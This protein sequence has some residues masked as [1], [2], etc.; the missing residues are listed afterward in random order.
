[1]CRARFGPYGCD[2]LTLPPEESA[3]G[4]VRYVTQ[5]HALCRIPCSA[6]QPAA[7]FVCEDDAYGLQVGVDYGAARETHAAAA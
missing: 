3:W 6:G 4:C 7:L 1:M 5:P 2:R